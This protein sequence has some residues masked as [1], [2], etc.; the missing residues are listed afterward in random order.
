MRQL[1]GNEFI[2]QNIDYTNLVNVRK[3]ALDEF[4]LPR[5]DLI[6]IDVEGMEMEVLA[7]AARSIERYHPVMLIE[8]I[9]ADATVLKMWL[10]SRGYVIL[11]AGIN[12]LVIHS[13][14]KVLEDVMPMVQRVPQ[15]AA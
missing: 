11:E 15:P 12:L 13:T 10:E 3:I 8:K 4:N 7:G 9:K 14:D 5:V 6:K 2:G 1:D